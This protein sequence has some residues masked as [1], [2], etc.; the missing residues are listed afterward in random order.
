M[1]ERMREPHGD[2]PDVVARSLPCERTKCRPRQFASQ[3]AAP[4]KPD[5]ARPLPVED[6]DASSDE[7]EQALQEQVHAAVDISVNVCLR[8]LMG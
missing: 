7:D 5:D 8:W 2:V 1:T 6:E 4:P 3:F